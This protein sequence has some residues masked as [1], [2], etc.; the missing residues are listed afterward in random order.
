MQGG[1]SLHSE[2]DLYLTINQKNTLLSNLF[3]IFNWMTL[4]DCLGVLSMSAE[5]DQGHHQDFFRTRVEGS[6]E[7]NTGE[8]NFS[9]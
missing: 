5:G 1:G 8:H 9:N 6:V 7:R 2:F 4:F 3:I